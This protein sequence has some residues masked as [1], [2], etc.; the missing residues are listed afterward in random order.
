MLA[1]L[2]AFALSVSA[3]EPSL[4]VSRPTA[5]LLNEEVE[6]KPISGHH[7]NVEAP[8]K[9]GGAKADSVTPRRF[10]CQLR[11]SGKVEIVTSVCDDAKTF[12][13]QERFK[14]KV[15]GAWKKVFRANH[16][17]KSHPAPPGF[18]T[19][20][21][22]ALAKAK[23][24][25][26]PIFA[27]F[28][29]IW[30]PPCN[31]L[32]EG[33][34]PTD[35]FK[36]ASAGFVKLALDA[37]SQLSWDWKERYKIGAYPTLLVL[38]E[39]GREIS[40]AVG[41]RSPE[42]LKAFL[43]EAKA[44]M[45]EPIERVDDAVAL[46][47]PAENGERRA[48]VARW[49]LER[50]EFAAAEAAAGAAPEARLEALLARQG[51]ASQQDDAPALT[52]A[53]KTLTAEFP[54][55][56]EFANWAESLADRD[57]PEGAALVDA[58]KASADRWAVD[59]GLSARGMV[60]GDVRAAQASYLEAIG[61]DSDAKAAWFAAAEAYDAQTA[62]SKLTLA[63]GANLERAYC[64]RK[65]GRLDEARALYASLISAYPN[66]FTFHYGYGRL[67][68]DLKD[69]P[70]ALHSARSAVVSGYGDNWLRAVALE[71]KTLKAL[72]RKTEAAR[73]LDA[74]LAEAAAPKSTAVRTHRYLAELRRLRAE[75]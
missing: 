1:F 36:K 11:S 55:E 29:G 12:C 31:M 72:N 7:F 64:L 69:F 20:T 33:V 43:A 6:L 60:P 62:D 71:I 28:F 23:R 65:A 3:S 22:K 2:A 42:T 16:P 49:R 10:R 14:V 52:A 4:V 74:A 61:H 15:G 18:L 73:S 34:Y 68:F 56:A 17:A 40:R 32:E 13:R 41:Y 45:R 35:T 58:V 38:D 46:S 5:A 44:L 39:Q 51:L 19:Q 9:C 66:E 75:L 26:A 8:Q 63:R 57:K 24:E 25:H 67:L 53:L 54:A 70:A 37:D 50:G 48:R 59:P 30:C 21:E 47:K 27:H